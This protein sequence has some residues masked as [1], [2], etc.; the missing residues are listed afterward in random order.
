MTLEER[1]IA[2]DIELRH[3]HRGLMTNGVFAHELVREASD[4]LTN[5]GAVY[6]DVY[7]LSGE[8]VK[9]RAEVVRLRGALEWYGE[10]TRLARLSH[11]EGD[12][13]R[14][15]L[16]RDGGKISRAALAPEEQ[17]ERNE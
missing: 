13:G 8:N 2:F 16:A 12:L 3:Q 9:L 6:G 10:N 14:D 1:L 11:S 17:P 5:Q 7:N 15:N 4:K